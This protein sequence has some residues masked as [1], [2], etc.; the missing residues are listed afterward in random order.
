MSHPSDTFEVTGYFL[1]VLDVDANKLLGTVPISNQG[2]WKLGFAG[3][4]FTVIQE[5]LEVMQGHKVRVIKASKS[6]PINAML[7]CQALCRRSKIPHP[8]DK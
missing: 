8:L 1:E 6:K 5:P 2:N 7:M 4:R 3:R